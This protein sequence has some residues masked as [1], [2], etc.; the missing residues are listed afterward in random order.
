MK[1][2]T[3]PE[4]MRLWMEQWRNAAAAL[5]DVKRLELMALTDEEAWRKT[6][7]LLS[8]PKPWRRPD[9]ECGLVEQQF[10]FHRRRS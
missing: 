1:L 6:E 5:E 8:L 4:E 9:R 10:W 2:A 3:S 7:P